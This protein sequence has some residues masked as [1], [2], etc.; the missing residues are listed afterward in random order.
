MLVLAT[1][2]ILPILC[3]YPPIYR[4]QNDPAG[5]NG[6]RD[7]TARKVF[8]GPKPDHPKLDRLLEE[9]RKIR[10]SDEQLREQAISFAY[11]NAPSS[12][13]ITKDSVRGTSNR[14]RISED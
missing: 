13:H 3:S 6:G 11:G 5:D 2:R 9:A 7:M 14:F 12:S 4:I 10:V 8:L 1:D